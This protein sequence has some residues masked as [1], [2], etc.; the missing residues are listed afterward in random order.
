MIGTLTVLPFESVFSGKLRPYINA[1]YD[2]PDATI[3]SIYEAA[4]D[5]KKTLD[6]IKL[7]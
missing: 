5:I 1:T 6:T 3:K 7:L 2:K 4:A